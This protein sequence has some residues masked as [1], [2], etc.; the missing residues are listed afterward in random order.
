MVLEKEIPLRQ[1]LE[2]EYGMVENQKSDEGKVAEEGAAEKE[3]EKEKEK[4]DSSKVSSSEEGDGILPP[5]SSG[6]KN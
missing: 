4:S 1:E 5:P 3:K 2:T 6:A